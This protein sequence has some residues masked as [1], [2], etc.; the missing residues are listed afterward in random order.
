M[1]R[2]CLILGFVLLGSVVYWPLLAFLGAVV[3]PISNVSADTY[4]VAIFLA[5]LVF[6]VPFSL[7]AF[8]CAFIAHLAVKGAE[9]NQGR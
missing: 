7:L 4:A 1:V 6:V 8:L 2:Y 5:A 9:R 3:D